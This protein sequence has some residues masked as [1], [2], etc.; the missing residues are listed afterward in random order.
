MGKYEDNRRF[1]QK[2]LPGLM[3][4]IDAVPPVKCKTETAKNGSLTLIYSLNGT[5]YYLHSK[6]N[7]ERE[8]EKILQNK[9]LEADHIVILGLGL[10]YH[11]QAIFEKKDPLARVLLVEPEIEILHHSLKVLDWAHLL[12][13]KDFF[14]VF[15][16][17]LNVIMETVHDFINIGAFDQL[18]FIELSSETRLLRSFFTKARETLDSE[19]KANIYD[20][21]TRLAESYMVPR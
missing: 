20:F 17:D 4:L 3:Q 10:G 6:F 12:K 8:S 2:E 21:K 7:P 11:L 14:Y 15:G 18:E 13:R 19:I 16:A 5:P 9:N 1:L